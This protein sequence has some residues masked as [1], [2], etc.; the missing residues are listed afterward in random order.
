MHLRIKSG[1]WLGEEFTDIAK[2]HPK[3]KGSHH[4]EGAPLSG[5]G[6][7]RVCSLNDDGS[8]YTEEKM[9]DYNP[10]EYSFKAEIKGAGGLPLDTTVSYM[11]LRRGSRIDETHCN[12]SLTMVYRTNPAFL[13]KL[14]KGKFRRNIEDYAIAIEHHVLTGEDVDPD[15]FKKIKKQYL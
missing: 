15:N 14:A 1:K 12:I 9:V 4:V 11:I 6:C 7:V 13:G 10:D 5:E 8:K 2:S 3:L